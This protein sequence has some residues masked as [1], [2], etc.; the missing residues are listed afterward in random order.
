MHNFNQNALFLFSNK[1][2]EY[3]YY[4][5]VLAFAAH[6]YGEIQQWASL[7]SKMILKYCFLFKET[8]ASLRNLWFRLEKENI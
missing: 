3:L 6:V 2:S 5:L 4:I 1:S 7:V 8:K